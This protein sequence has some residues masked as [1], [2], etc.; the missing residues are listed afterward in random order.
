MTRRSTARRSRFGLLA[1]FLGLWT[2]S[3]AGASAQAANSFGAISIKE[4]QRTSPMIIPRVLIRT[5]PGGVH[6]TARN[7]RQLIEYAYSIEDYQL[8]DSDTWTR[9]KLFTLDATTSAPASDAQLRVMM[10]AALQMRFGLRLADTKSPTPVF[11]LVIAPGGIKFRHLANGEKQIRHISR[12][13]TR[14]F[15]FTTTHDLV[16]MLDAVGAGRLLGRTLVDQTGLAG[17]FDIVFTMPQKP[18]RMYGR[19]GFMVDY[20]SEL[21]PALQKIGLELRP[22][23][24]EMDTYRIQAAHPPTPN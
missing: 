17:R 6:A 19:E 14:I 5:D 11:A 15:A 1:V 4:F 9:G 18:A 24:V 20:R 12:P 13:D 16:A 7:L 2:G 22:E 23:V 21:R 3:A 8:V 10:R